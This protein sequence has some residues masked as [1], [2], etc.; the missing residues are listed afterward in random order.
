MVFVIEDTGLSYGRRKQGV[1]NWLVQVPADQNHL[2]VSLL[3]SVLVQES[4]RRR[5]FGIPGFDRTVVED[6]SLLVS[7]VVV[8]PA[9]GVV[10]PFFRLLAASGILVVQPSKA[11]YFPQF[12]LGLQLL[13]L[14]LCRLEPCKFDANEPIPED[15]LLINC[16]IA[17]YVKGQSYGEDPR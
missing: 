15:D 10:S 14:V 17:C 4:A 6:P 5:T 16:M 3:L 7:R 11:S 13:P 12:S 1:D 2:S 9:A 8:G